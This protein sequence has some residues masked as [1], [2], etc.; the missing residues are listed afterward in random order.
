M[1]LC[2]PIGSPYEG[3]KFILKVNFPFNCPFEPPKITFLTPIYHPNSSEQ[4]KI[5]LDILENEWSALLTLSK[6]ILSISSLLN[7]PNP[8]D[9]LREDIAA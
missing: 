2:G 3:G 6:C 5:C 8:A 7:D 4:G 9:S 1:T